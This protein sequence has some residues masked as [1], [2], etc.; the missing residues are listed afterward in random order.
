[1]AKEIY[2]SASLSEVGFHS[3]LSKV[4]VLWGQ[5]EGSSGLCFKYVKR[6]TSEVKRKKLTTGKAVVYFGSVDKACPT[7]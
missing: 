5:E 7:L 1:M 3:S 2:F 6:V 4:T